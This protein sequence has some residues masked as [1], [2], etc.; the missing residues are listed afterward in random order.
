LP[1]VTIAMR[2]ER[3][4][5]LIGFPWRSPSGSYEID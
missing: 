3:S 1:P 4:N 2:P 5:K